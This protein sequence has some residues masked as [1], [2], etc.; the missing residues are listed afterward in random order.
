MQVQGQNNI[1]SWAVCWAGFLQKTALSV[2][3]LLLASSVI[4]WIAANWAYASVFQ[5]LAGV[6][7]LLILLVLLTVWLL[8]T[9]PYRHPNFSAAAQTAGLAA[10]CLGG[11]LALV[12]QIYQTGADPWQLFMWWAVLLVPWLFSMHTVFFGLLIA[13][14]LNIVAVLYFDASQAGGW[15]WLEL[16]ASSLGLLLLATNALMLALWE[17][18]SGY[19]EDH[20]RIGQRVLAIS[21]GAWAVG[22]S[23]ADGD[24]GLLGL[25]VMA[26]AAWFYSQKRR[27]VAIVAVA[28]ITA[29][30]LIAISLV[31]WL[32]SVEGLLLVI[33]LLLG[34]TGLMLA[35]MRRLLSVA[36][37]AE[38]ARQNDEKIHDPWFIS[39]FRLSAMMFTAFLVIALLFM[40]LDL[41]TEQLWVAGLVTIVPGVLIVRASNNNNG[42]MHQAGATLTCAG[43]FMLGAGLYLMDSAASE[44]RAVGIACA[45]VLVYGLVGGFALRWFVSAFCLAVVLLITWPG[46]FL[47]I[48]TYLRLWWLA[49]FAILALLVSGKSQNNHPWAPMAWA[50]VVLT[51]CLA[52]MLPVFGFSLW[53]QVWQDAWP[54]AML[55]GACAF[56]PVIVLATLL[57]PIRALTPGLRLGAPLI[58]AVACLGWIGAPGVSLGVLWLLLGFAQRRRSLMVVGVLSTLLYLGVFYYRLEMTLLHKSFLLGATGLWL[59]AGGWMLRRLLGGAAPTFGVLLA[60]GAPK[61]GPDCTNA[62]IG[63]AA[64]LSRRRIF[65]LAAGLVLMLVV[66]NWGIYQHENTLAHGDAVVLE[67]APVDPRSLMQGDYMALEFDIARQ[68]TQWWPSLPDPIRQAVEKQGMGYVVV[69]P[70]PQG[71]HRLYGVQASVGGPLAVQDAASIDLAGQ[72]AFTLIDASN[73]ASALDADVVLEFRRRDGRIRVVTDAWFFPEGQGEYFSHAR[74]GKV[75]VNAKGEGLLEQMLDDHL[76]PL[77]TGAPA[78]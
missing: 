70:D 28:G 51:Q 15:P 75:R 12:G 76:K 43:L 19:L 18:L 26:L 46:E 2:G 60:A 35:Y 16:D 13:L 14:L 33:V 78:H 58:L 20:W 25:P 30:S 32:D 37:D 54:L 39:V 44:W 68:L 77:G 7:T 55:A 59:V 69:A 74:Y 67:L 45:G 9:R 63:N 23:V 64:V 72:S 49:V 11:L 24:A 52:M 8:C 27:D 65:G 71:V 53:R 22:A 61:P 21:A 62:S 5:K 10:V 3:S 73:A 36:T 40:M 4:S 17:R 34:L 57:W 41:D 66:V 31:G 6:Q 56:L 1:P 48:P 29:L 42:G 50:L 47:D 38:P